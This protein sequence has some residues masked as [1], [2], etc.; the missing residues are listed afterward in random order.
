MCVRERLSR[1]IAEDALAALPNHRGA[2]RVHTPPFARFRGVSNQSMAWRTAAFALLAVVLSACGGAGGGGSASV[3]TVPSTPAPTLPA[4]TGVQGDVAFVGTL[5]PSAAIAWDDDDRLLFAVQGKSITVVGG[6]LFAA[7]PP[8]D[9]DAF[10]RAMAYSHAKRAIYFASAT[11][12]YQA[13]PAGAVSVLASG[14][15]QI[16]GLCV[17]L[18]GDVFAVDDDH[19]ATVSNGAAKPISPPGTVTDPGG[20]PLGFAVPH[21]TFDTTDGALYVTDPVNTAV[22]RVTTSGSVTTVAGSCA[23]AAGGG[24][25]FCYPGMVP[26]SGK[27]AHLAAPSD[28]AYDASADRFFVADSMDHVLWTMTPSGTTAIAAGYGAYGSFRGNGRHAILMLPIG[29]A[30]S[31]AD[32]EL[33]LDD[34]DFFGTFSE[35]DSYVTTGSQPPQ[36]P[37]PLVAELTTPT[38]NAMPGSIAEAPDGTAWISEQIGMTAH[39]TTNGITEYPAAP[40]AFRIVVD[41]SANAWS[42]TTSGIFSPSVTRTAPDGTQTMFNLVAPNSNGAL[43]GLTI[44]PDGN[45]WLTYQNANISKGGA[46]TVAL[47]TID[48]NSGVIT[49]FPLPLGIAG[50]LATGPDGTLWLSAGATPPFSIV[51][52]ATTGQVVATPYAVSWFPRTLALDTPDQSVW[53]DDGAGELARVAL[54]GAET[55][56]TLCNDCSFDPAAGAIAPAPDGSVWFTQ[57]NPGN[58]GHREASGTVTHYLLPGYGGGA[59][60]NGIAVRP[61]GKVWV[62]T[63]EGRVFLF[64]AAA[65]DALGFP[66]PTPSSTKRQARHF[67]RSAVFGS[68]RAPL[69]AARARTPVSG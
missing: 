23:L 55:V 38:F 6:A 24:I 3:A 56:T 48:R 59:S 4:S 50:A 68:A 45:P 16:E 18:A 17:D 7:M 54:S 61:D 10:V 29:L 9:P 52:V 63:L 27:G 36:Q 46:T 5:N 64:D 69:P 21:V 44:G 39:V 33:Y 22:K 57:A 35:I 43:G 51:R 13:T 67:N 26:G 1:G 65:Y 66:H 28:I 11:T 20:D 62:T 8:N 14:F 58:I 47:E 53:Y 49:S 25:S 34:C 31:S 19:I 30:L 12:I 2:R 40:S 37:F 15:R 32:H 60:P 41:G 42:S